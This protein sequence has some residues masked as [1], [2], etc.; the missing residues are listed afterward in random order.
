MFEDE[1]DILTVAPARAAAAFRGLLH[2]VS[3][4]LCD[5]SELMSAEEAIDVLLN[6]VTTRG[7]D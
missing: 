4:P 7:E 1:A 3:F 2:A 5:P 6:G